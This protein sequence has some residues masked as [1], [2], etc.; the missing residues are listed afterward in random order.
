M[1]VLN[2]GSESYITEYGTLT[3][4]SGIGTFD[5]YANSSKTHLRYTPPSNVDVET[6]VFQQAIQ[7]V[8]VDDTLDHEIDLNNTSITAGYGFYEGTQIGIKRAFELTHDG[9]PIFQR[10]F[11]GSNTDIVDTTNNTIRIPDHFFTTGEPVNYSVGVIIDGID[12]TG[13]ALGASTFDIKQIEELEINEIFIENDS[14][15]H[16]Q[17]VYITNYYLPEIIKKL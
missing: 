16:L 11:D 13:I 4:G 6:R 9:L 12:F 15:S 17:P 1:I 8:S 3:T 2:D 7:L 10:N 14:Y 5:A